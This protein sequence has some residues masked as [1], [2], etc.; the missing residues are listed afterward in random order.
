V[1]EIASIAGVGIGLI[2]YHFQTKENLINICIMESISHTVTAFQAYSSSA[3]TQSIDKIKALGKG[4]ATFMVKNPGFSKI[5]ITND[6]ISPNAG[7]NNAQLI[8]MLLP[9]VRDIYSGK[10]DESE[11]PILLHML[12]SSIQAAFLRKAVLKET[13]GIDFDDDQQRD[14]FIETCINNVFPQ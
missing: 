5:S 9:A 2:N 10:K 8:K 4:I 11:L 14:K 13:I 12:V 6:F 3:D 1:R 7:D